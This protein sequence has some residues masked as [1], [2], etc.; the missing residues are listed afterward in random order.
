MNAFCR[1]SPRLSLPHLAI[2]WLSIVVALAALETAYGQGTV[3]ESVDIRHILEEAGKTVEAI[4]NNDF[5]EDNYP[6]RRWKIEAFQDV[7]RMQAKLG[8]QA[9]LKRTAQ[10]AIEVDRGNS[11]PDILPLASIARTQAEAGD[12]SGASVTLKEVLRAVEAID[13]LEHPIDKDSAKDAVLMLVVS[14]QVE[15]DNPQEV[16]KT[17]NRVKDDQDRADALTELARIRT[18]HGDRKTARMLLQ[19]AVPVAQGLKDVD[20]K[21]WVLGNIARAQAE[22][23]DMPAAQRTFEQAR[24]SLQGIEDESDRVHAMQF[25]AIVQMAMGDKATAQKWLSQALN[26]AGTIKKS[27]DKVDRLQSI[28][29]DQAK[30]GDRASAMA[31]LQNALNAANAIT[32]RSSKVYGLQKIAEAYLTLGENNQAREAL[33]QALKVASEIPSPRDR[34]FVLFANE[35]IHLYSQLGDL[36]GA[37]R[38]IG[39]MDLGD[40]ST[41]YALVELINVEATQGDL[42]SAL[43]W[44]GTLREMNRVA[45]ASEGTQRIAAAKA[46]HEGIQKALSWARSQRLPYERARA[47]LGVAEGGEEQ[48]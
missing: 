21:A 34:S 12:Y 48:K 25:M 14:V 1:V 5:V 10:R 2:Y 33:N 16:L 13:K 8:D 30:W 23:D 27:S 32:E 40:Y 39:M 36:E 15:V 3:E 29:L 11:L 37:R 47:I 28:A 4:D 20:Q 24:Q 38:T 43:K 19:Q 6:A 35:V 18:K 46:R 41:G 45:L 22:A 7:V 44:V 42:N 17:I 26:N 9:G 31:T